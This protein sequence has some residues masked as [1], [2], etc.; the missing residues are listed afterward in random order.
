MDS[1][2]LPYEMIMLVLSKLPQNDLALAGRLT[3]SEAARKYKDVRFR[4]SQPLHLH[5][6]EP[7]E[8]LIQS[9]MAALTFRQKL[10]LLAVAA[11]SG[12]EAN[13]AAAWELLR[14]NL[15]PELLP[16]NAAAEAPGFG[17]SYHISENENAGRVACERGHPHLVKWM[18]D[19]GCLLEP[20]DTLIAATQ[21]C[22]LD[23][24][25]GIWELLRPLLDLD[26][27]CQGVLQVAAASAT[28]DVLDKV[29]WV[30]EAGAGSCT[31]NSRVAAAAIY[32]VA[33]F[34]GLGEEDIVGVVLTQLAWLQERGCP[35]TG[36]LPLETAM[37]LPGSA[38][39]RVAEWLQAEGQEQQQQGQ[40]PDGEQGSNNLALL[41]PKAACELV[42]AVVGAHSSP[43]SGDSVAKLRWLQGRG[44]PLPER[45]LSIV[46]RAGDLDAVCYLCEEHDMLLTD[47]VFEAAARSGSMPLLKWLHTSGCPM[48]GLTYVAAAECGS[49][50]VVQWLLQEAGCPMGDGAECLFGMMVRDWASEEVGRWSSV[51]PLS[52]TWGLGEDTD[53]LV[54]VRLLVEAGCTA[55]NVLKEAAERG[56]M[57]LVRFLVE[58]LK[59]P[60]GR[61]EVAAAARSGCFDLVRYM[62]EANGGLPQPFRCTPKDVYAAAAANGDLGTLLELRRLEMPWGCGTLQE[63]VLDRTPLPVLRWMVQQGMPAGVREVGEVLRI[64]VEPDGFIR[65]V[66]YG[67][68]EWLQEL[69]GEG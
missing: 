64:V 58:D 67:V 57:R 37:R 55:R 3:C 30:L 2:L 50:E 59:R 65:R 43:G 45:V 19:H 13:M 24:L 47:E 51:H 44:M 10:G 26:E 42:A 27:S 1:L 41:Q 48:I 31:L 5:L 7:F 15:H 68:L 62:L 6:L 61:H 12:C 20:C 4:L 38:A 60:V 40:N 29:A 22:S 14:P 33:R 53:L 23:A 8:P 63:A 21:H 28:G 17:F 54:L 16:A 32:G 9:R 39:L 34:S 49:L 52:R 69:A 36:A 25:R 56:D 66:G 18:L 35:L 46:A 11:A